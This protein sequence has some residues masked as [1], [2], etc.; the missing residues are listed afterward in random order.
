MLQLLYESIFTKLLST[1]IHKINIYG[2]SYRHGLKLPS[3]PL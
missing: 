1:I 2:L 3:Y